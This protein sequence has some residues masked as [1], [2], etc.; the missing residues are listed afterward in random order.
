MFIIKNI[1]NEQRNRQKL[2]LE[3]GDIQLSAYTKQSEFYRSTLIH[4]VGPG[5]PTPGDLNDFARHLGST[6]AKEWS[7]QYVA[8]HE[9]DAIGAGLQS[10]NDGNDLNI[11]FN[12]YR[13]KPTRN[14]PVLKIEKNTYNSGDLSDETKANKIKAYFIANQGLGDIRKQKFYQNNPTEAQKKA[15]RTKSREIY[16]AFAGNDDKK[17]MPTLNELGFAL[18]CPLSDDGGREAIFHSNTLR[19]L[20]LESPR[21]VVKLKSDERHKV[22]KSIDEMRRQESGKRRNDINAAIDSK[23]VGPR[24]VAVL[25]NQGH[26]TAP[27]KSYGHLN[28][29]Q[30]SS[31]NTG[32]DDEESND[33]ETSRN[34]RR[35]NNNKNKKN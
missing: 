4:P 8:L 5:Q 13:L 34:N 10:D 24:I 33:F 18:E 9:S 23:Y 16:E 11:V 27:K 1:G 19:F 14:I 29:N 31:S 20:R 26:A 17:L 7:G 6:P 12:L 28:L 32:A 35:R 3:D 15:F 21:L 30:A 22:Y 2:T 25:A